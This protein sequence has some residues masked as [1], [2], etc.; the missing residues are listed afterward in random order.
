VRIAGRSMGWYSVRPKIWTAA[1]TV[2]PPAARTMPVI[3]S[4]P[5][6]RPQGEV[7]ERFVAAPSPAANR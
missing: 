5:I 6:H 4:K 1:P 2:N 3:M 7:C